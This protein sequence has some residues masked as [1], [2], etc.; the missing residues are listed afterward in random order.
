VQLIA[1][2]VLKST[3]LHLC[4]AVQIHLYITSGFIFNIV[5]DNQCEYD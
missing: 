3:S 2:K 5:F 1:P 4:W